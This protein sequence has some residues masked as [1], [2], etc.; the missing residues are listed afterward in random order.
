MTFITGISL[1]GPSNT[2]RQDSK[3]RNTR[4]SG[5]HSTKLSVSCSDFG[6]VLEINRNNGTWTEAGVRVFAWLASADSVPKK[7]KNSRSNREHIQHRPMVLGR[8]GGGDTYEVFCPS[9]VNSDGR[10][11]GQRVQ[12]K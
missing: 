6:T 3:W 7:K 2:E 9:N 10:G 11:N 8:R 5:L 4:A 12:L 1:F